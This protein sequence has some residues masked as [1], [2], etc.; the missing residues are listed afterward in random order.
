MLSF[1]RTAAAD[2]QVLAIKLTI[3]RTNR[4][5]PIVQALVEAARSGKQV[6]VLVEVT[7]RFDEA[8]NIA[9]GQFLEKEGVH[10]TYGVQKLKT[11]VKLALAVREEQGRI[12]RYIQAGTGNYHTGTARFYE[13]LGLLTCHPGLCEDV[14]ALFN[15]LTGATPCQN[16][17]KLIVAPRNMRQ[18]FVELIQ[19]EIEHAKAGRPCGIR[20]KMN[21]LQDLEMIKALY[22]ASQ[23]GVPVALNVRG[24]C[25][26]LPGVPGL[27]ETIRVISL[28]GRFLEHSRIYC[29]NNGG[30]IEYYVGSAD[31]M[32]RNLDNRV[33]TIIPILSPAIK[34]QLAEILD[35]YDRDNCSVW[36]CRPDGQYLRRQPGSGEERRAAQEMFIQLAHNEAGQKSYWDR[37][38]A[39]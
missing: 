14:A 27:S 4:D 2:P 30:D 3:Y 33:E 5:S 15:E 37:E 24:L 16:Y 32:W 38:E 9:W 10:V 12:R 35:V 1:I 19:R 6:A 34:K 31:W 18:R 29:F 11:H 26:L 20:A 17:R 28:V 21:Q 8:P 23:A 7:A 22:S 36:D 39:L 25:C 13:D